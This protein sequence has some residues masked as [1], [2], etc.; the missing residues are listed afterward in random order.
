MVDC[1][2]SIAGG[3]LMTGFRMSNENSEPIRRSNQQPFIQYRQHKL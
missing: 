3:S 2:L 1:R